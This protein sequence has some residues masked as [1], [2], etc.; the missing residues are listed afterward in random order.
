VPSTLSLAI[1]RRTAPPTSGHSPT[2]WLPG[3]SC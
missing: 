1:V 2:S 3:T